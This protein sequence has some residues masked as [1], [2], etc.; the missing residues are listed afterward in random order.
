MQTALS[1]FNLTPPP[2]PPHILS[3][4]S[5]F[6]TFHFSSSPSFLDSHSIQFNLTVSL[7]VVLPFLLGG[8]G[9]ERSNIFQ[10]EVGVFSCD[11]EEEGE[12][13]RR[14]KSF[15][16]SFIEVTRPPKDQDGRKEGIHSISVSIAC[17]LQ[18]LLHHPQWFSTVHHTFLTH[19]PLYITAPISVHKSVLIEYSL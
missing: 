18:T 2:P 1:H 3:L 15:W 14:K 4:F 12:M 5:S 6:T 16:V 7:L 8:Y 17:F 19:I 13:E 11:T 10:S 9:G